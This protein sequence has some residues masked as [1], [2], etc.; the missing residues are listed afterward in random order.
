M[1]ILDREKPKLQVLTE[2]EICQRMTPKDLDNAR[3]LLNFAAGQYQDKIL[4]PIGRRMTLDDVGILMG[5]IND[6]VEPL[7]EK[8]AKWQQEL[9]ARRISRR[10]FLNGAIGWG[11]GGMLALGTVSLV[12][13]WIDSSVGPE[14]Q[15]REFAYRQWL[16]AHN[17]LG[18]SASSPSLNRW[19]VRYAPADLRLVPAG[20]SSDTL[21]EGT[22]IQL[23]GNKLGAL[24]S[25]G[26]IIKDH[27]R[28]TDGQPVGRLAIATGNRNPGYT[29]GEEW[30]LRDQSTEAINANVLIVENLDSKTAQYLSPVR[31]KTVDSQKP[32][33]T[34]WAYK[35]AQ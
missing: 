11:V 23:A 22:M 9:E 28:T 15:K 7:R 5:K 32:T 31:S 16:E 4:S 26:I 25:T 19:T 29:I 20:V 24:D 18:L 8:S 21:A 13:S 3:D 34:L 17:T 6:L 10:R 27:I 14:A 33:F 12:W 30:V 1:G 35:L 2:E